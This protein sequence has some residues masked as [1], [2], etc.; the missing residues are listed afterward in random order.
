MYVEG[1]DPVW[2]MLVIRLCA[3]LEEVVA[4]VECPCPVDELVAMVVTSLL[5]LVLFVVDVCGMAV[6]LGQWL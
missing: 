2:A 5:T 3:V 1:V 6:V 4:L